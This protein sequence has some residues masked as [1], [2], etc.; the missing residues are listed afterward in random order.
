MNKF[1]EQILIFAGTEEEVSKKKKK[2]SALSSIL[3]LTESLADFSSQ[4]EDVKDSIDEEDVKTKLS[5][6]DTH[7][8]A[9][10]NELVELIR[11]G[12]SKTVAREE[13]E[14]SVAKTVAKEITPSRPSLVTSPSIPSLPKGSF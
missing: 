3:K 7:V 9:M 8:E 4:I 12:I 10:Y 6:F 2:G 14:A 13:D 11:A 1:N 5:E